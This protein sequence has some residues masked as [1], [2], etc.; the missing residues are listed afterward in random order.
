M[1]KIPIDKYKEL[2]QKV[3]MNK[4]ETRTIYLSPEDWNNSYKSYIEHEEAWWEYFQN[5]FIPKLK[6]SKSKKITLVFWESGPAVEDIEENQLPH[7]N[8][9]F[10]RMDDL[11]NSYL[12][13]VCEK[14]QILINSKTTKKEALIKLSEK[15][16]LI[17]DLYPTHG[18]K[19]GGK[20]VR[21]KLVN[22][23]DDY[24][25]PKLKEV[26]ECTDSYKATFFYEIYHLPF[27][28]NQKKGKREFVYKDR[29]KNKRILEI[30][31]SEIKPVLGKRKIIF[32]AYDYS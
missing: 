23:F 24:T 21:D 9:S 30:K 1:Y 5:I 29:I 27:L 32:K 13:K 18:I 31:S 19:L 10:Y 22:I 17:I 14:A 2:I 4:Y 3:Y 12:K 11:R 8:Y 15:K 26:K 7:K 16:W 6:N 25:I 20:G 28:N